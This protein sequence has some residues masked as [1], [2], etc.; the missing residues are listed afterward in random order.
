MAMS[1]K[2]FSDKSSI[3]SDSMAET[4][5]WQTNILI[6]YNFVCHFEPLEKC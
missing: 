2:C 3:I 6:Q 5:A 4:E 1:E